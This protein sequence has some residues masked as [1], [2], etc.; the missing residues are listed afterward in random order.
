MEQAIWAYIGIIAALFGL[1]VVAQIFLLNQETV[2]QQEL[3]ISLEKLGN[4]CNFVCRNAAG[5]L[6]KEPATLASGSVF[7]TSGN[8]LC[9][10]YGEAENCFRCDCELENYTLNL[11][12]EEITQ[13]YSIHDFSCSLEKR[14]GGLVRVACTG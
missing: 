2:K 9:Y 14:S 3:E 4:R 1:L 7:S 10:S 8:A 12:T 11:N 13:L 6:I 5:T